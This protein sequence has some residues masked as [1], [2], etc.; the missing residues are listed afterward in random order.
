MKIYVLYETLTVGECSHKYFLDKSI[1]ECELA[2]EEHWYK[3]AGIECY[4]K[5]K[6]IETED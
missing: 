6:E 3:E 5:I 1:A 2:G 4:W